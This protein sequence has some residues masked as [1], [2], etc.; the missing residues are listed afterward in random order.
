MKKRLTRMLVIPVAAILLPV[1]SQ[2]V[3]MDR[4]LMIKPIDICD[5]DGKNCAS[6][7][8]SAVQTQTVYTQAGVTVL[9]EPTGQISKSSL[10]NVNG[11]TDV[12]IPGNGQSSNA[13]TLNLW[14]ANSLIYKPDPK[15]TL[16]GNAFLG[17]NG[18]VINASAVDTS[19]RFSTVPHEIGHNLGLAHNDFGAGG[20][21]NVMTTGDF[22][23]PLA[24][25]LTP[26]QIDQLRKSDFVQKNPDVKV[27]LVGSTAFDTD[28]FFK[29]NF[30]EGPT[31]VSL[32]KLTIDL[33]PAKAFFDPTENTPGLS[34]SP[35]A[36]SG[37]NGITFSD[38]TFSGL[39]DGS[40]FLTINFAPGTFTKG[41]SFAFGSD[42]DLYSNIDGYGATPEE[43]IGIKFGFDFNI[44]L[45]LKSTLDSDLITGT[46]D[47]T[48][49]GTFDVPLTT[50]G[51]Q[52]LSGQ[53]PP[54]SASPTSIDP[55]YT[56]PVPEPSTILLYLTG[57]AMLSF[58]NR[59]RV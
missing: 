1:T 49:S 24:S 36:I 26:Q 15:A 21:S 45:S 34:G 13:N 53:L 50:Y 39:T 31:N 17:G 14:F 23:K 44:G 59:R 16:F 55:V 40:T 57:F 3:T 29:V 25:E 30:G 51:P 35:L 12:N 32:T 20:A 11:V 47:A 2:A 27:D 48:E 22:R 10:L 41:D 56:T 54:G 42:I 7:P 28:N 8:I 43:L 38:M 9:Y 18:V 5:D 52:V 46:L 19:G 6:M 37:L 58:V 4:F 33:S